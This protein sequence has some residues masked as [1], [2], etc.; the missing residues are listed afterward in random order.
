MSWPGHDA[1]VRDPEVL[2]QLARLGE[3]HDRAPEPLAEIADGRADGRDPPDELVVG[4]LARLPRAA[5]A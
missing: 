2:E 1:D 3:V 5:T 4:R